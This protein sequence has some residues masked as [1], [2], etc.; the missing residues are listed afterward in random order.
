MHFQRS[1]A[2]YEWL[3]SAV[4]GKIEIKSTSVIR[5]D[6]FQGFAGALHSKHSFIKFRPTLLHCVNAG[7]LQHRR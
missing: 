6:S 1:L 5:I 7:V 4:R 2:W 3:R